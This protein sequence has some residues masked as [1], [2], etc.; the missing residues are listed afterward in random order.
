MICA[1][2]DQICSQVWWNVSEHFG[3]VT[4]VVDRYAA[5][6]GRLALCWTDEAGGEIEKK[7]AIRDPDASS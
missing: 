5:D 1:R 6:S 7:R 2:Y 4:G 3:F